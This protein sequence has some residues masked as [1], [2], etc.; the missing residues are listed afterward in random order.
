[1]SLKQFALDP[2]SNEQIIELIKA[3]DHEAIIRHNIKLL[4][5]ISVHYKGKGVSQE[6]L[7]TVGAVGYIDAIAK[8]SPERG[9]FTTYAGFWVRR[10]MRELF[11]MEKTITISSAL[12]AILSNINK[13]AEKLEREPTVEEVMK[14]FDSTKS[15]AR[16]HLFERNKRIINDAPL[17]L[18][19]AEEN[20]ASYEGELDLVMHILNDRETYIIN[21]RYGLEEG[22]ER[23]SLEVVSLELNISRERVRQVQDGALKKM[24][25]E[26]MEMGIER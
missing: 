25:L 15:A 26:L 18:V 9:M 13:F 11:R 22:T 6:E 2:V 5:K 12:V 16:R 1:M 7:V 4:Y 17:A 21:K 19:A 10:R 24:K 8:Y 20:R 14:E 23:E 3:G